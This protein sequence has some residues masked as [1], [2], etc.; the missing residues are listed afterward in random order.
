MNYLVIDTSSKHLIILLSKRGEVFTTYIEDCNTDHSTKLMVE[1]DKMLKEK[2]VT[3]FDMDFFGVVV[4]P[5]SFTGIRIGVATVKAFSLAVNKP[6]LP[7][8]SFD[9]IAYNKVDGKF[10]AVID[11][12]HD[13][14]YAEGVE[15]GKITLAPCFI[16]KERVL[17][18]K[19]E[20]ALISFDDIEG[21]E[22]VCPVEG[23]KKAVLE[24]KEKVTFDMN[25]VTP[26]YIR[27]SQ[28][29]EN[30]WL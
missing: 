18:L 22:K 16:N 25:L 27:K 4:G 11:A 15:D 2:G 24:N 8:T 28:A 21:V 23:L 12:K 26:L 13:N 9:T 6:V 20:Y 30:R 14:F 10:L 5:G 29:E 17:E 1:V 7:L 3:L 19:K